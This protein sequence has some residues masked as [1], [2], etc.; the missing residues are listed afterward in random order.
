MGHG[1]NNKIIIKGTR[2]NVVAELNLGQRSRENV[3][4]SGNWSS[5]LRHLRI[6]GSFHQFFNSQTWKIAGDKQRK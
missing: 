6:S 2:A 3:I 4:Y 1:G 5:E